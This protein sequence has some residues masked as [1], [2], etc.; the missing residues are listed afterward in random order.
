MFPNI[1]KFTCRRHGSAIRH[2]EYSYVTRPNPRHE[3][4]K[5]YKEQWHQRDQS[6]GLRN[7]VHKF[8]RDNERLPREDSVKR[9]RIARYLSRAGC[10]GQRGVVD[11]GVDS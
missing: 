5:Y 1:S 8:A 4:R 10:R 2:L 6:E 7:S 11:G 3:I 9:F